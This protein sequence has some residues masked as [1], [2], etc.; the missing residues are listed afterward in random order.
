M[1]KLYNIAVYDP[2]MWEH[3]TNP[4]IVDI[5]AALL[6]T[7]DLKMYEDQLFMKAPEVA[8]PRPG[9]RIRLRGAIS[10]RWIWCRRGRLLMPPRSTTAA[11][12]LPPEPIAGAC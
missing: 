10:C 6:G 1:R 9:I 8:V 11:C 2:V 5:I 12:T 4:K 3:A 7:D